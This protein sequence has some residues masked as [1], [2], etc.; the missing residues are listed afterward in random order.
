MSN[1]NYL[2]KGANIPSKK[3]VLGRGL[4]ALMSASAV[5]VDLMPK[6]ANKG[7]VPDI[8][9]QT[10]PFAE[11][12]ETTKFASYQNAFP[13]EIAAQNSAVEGGLV[14]LS[15]D[16]I[17]ANVDQPRRHFAEDEI[18]KLAESLRKTGLLQPII[19]R[20]KQ[21]SA[22]QNFEIV[23]GER[24][25]R[26]AKLAGLENIPAI[27]KKL[28]DRETLELGII[29]NIQRAD[30]N[31]ID[32]A[33]AYQRLVELYG[34]SQSEVAESVGKDRASVA[35]AIRL[36]KLSPA[37]QELLVQG[38]LSAGHGRTLISIDNHQEQER[39]AQE[40]IIENLSVRATE[41]YMN[42]YKLTQKDAITAKAKDAKKPEKK[43][44]PPV[45]AIEERLRRALGTKVKVLI[46]GKDKG[47]LRLSFYSHEELEN[48]LE[49]LK[50]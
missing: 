44:L 22:T 7:L 41:S 18:N 1:T 50:A 45:S 23:A 24:R 43:A 21:I 30:L 34:A 48:I 25:Y 26:A 16:S 14:Y 9:E 32:E 40:I 5:A 8:I 4:S 20:P 38:K 2:P 3:N 49:R 46:K 47:E 17:A 29:E 35:N 31:P 12:E 27:I 33:H 19:V 36:L 42:Q 37:V 11:R 28:T 15:L 13:S 6:G 39:I 10:G